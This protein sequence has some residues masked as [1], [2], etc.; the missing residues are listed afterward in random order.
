LNEMARQSK[1][2]FILENVP[3][4]KDVEKFAKHYKKSFDSLV[5]HTG[6]DYEIVFTAPKKYKSKITTIA[7]A[8]RTPIVEIGSV[9]KGN[10][11]YIQKDKLVK[12]ADKGYHH[13]ISN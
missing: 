4:K 12:I 5:F 7:K 9:I 1:C 11:V 3:A 8:T 6:E 2:R 10:G 13:F